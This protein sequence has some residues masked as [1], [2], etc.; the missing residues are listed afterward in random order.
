MRKGEILGPLSRPTEEEPETGGEFS[1]RRLQAE[2]SCWCSRHWAFCSETVRSIIIKPPRLP[3]TRADSCESRAAWRGACILESI[4]FQEGGGN[5]STSTISTTKGTSIPG[6]PVSQRCRRHLGG[7]WS[8]TFGKRIW[9]FLI[10]L[11]MYLSHGVATEPPP[12]IYPR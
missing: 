3:L 7:K 6:K 12:G 11:H 2:L 9:Q 4:L 5:H 8:F 1:A 10:K